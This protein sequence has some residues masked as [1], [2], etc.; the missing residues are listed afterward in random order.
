MPNGGKGGF[1]LE[2][3]ERLVGGDHPLQQHPQ[4]STVPL[5]PSEIEEGVLFDLLR[6]DLEE[7]VESGIGPLDLQAVREY[8]QR[9]A[10]RLHDGLGVLLSGM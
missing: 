1:N 4:R 5:T 2:V 10:Y 8:H 7:L 3:G 9:H 6:V